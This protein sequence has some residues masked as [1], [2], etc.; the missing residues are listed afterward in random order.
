MNFYLATTLHVRPLA[1]SV[2]ID[3]THGESAK[4]YVS[5]VVHAAN[6]TKAQEMLK[7]ALDEDHYQLLSPGEWRVLIK[8]E[9]SNSGDPLLINALNESL[10]SGVGYV[11]FDC[12]PD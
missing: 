5:A 9:A 6:L 2:L 10:S 4:A 12:Y 7:L 11:R 1:G 8:E 3:Q